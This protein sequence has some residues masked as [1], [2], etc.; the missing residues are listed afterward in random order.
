MIEIENDG[1]DEWREY[2]SD[3]L[4]ET[5]EGVFSDFLENGYYRK[6]PER[7]LNAFKAFVTYKTPINKKIN[8]VRIDIEPSSEPELEPPLEPDMKNG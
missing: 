6:N 4:H 3:M 7:L 8:S 5:L 1:Y 2:W